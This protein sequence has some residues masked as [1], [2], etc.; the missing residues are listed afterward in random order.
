MSRMALAVMAGCALIIAGYAAAVLLLPGFGAPFVQDLRAATPF[1]L[2]AH[3]GGGALAL[4]LG[5]WQFSSR[6][7]QRTVRV[8]RWVGRAYLLAVLLGGVGALLLTPGSMHGLVTHVGFGLLGVL[9]LGTTL[10][11]WLAIRDRDTAAH[12]RWMTRS[13]ALTLAAVTLRIWLPLSAVAGIPF[14]DAYQVV[15]WLCWVPNLIV[16]EW[17]LLLPAI[18]EPKG[19]G[20]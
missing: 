7:R 17:F 6:I 8:H 16:A 13:F 5:P 1:A 19:V 10:R 18:R 15:S 11:A 3:L 4:A 9:W 12:R 20:A 14:P 2:Y